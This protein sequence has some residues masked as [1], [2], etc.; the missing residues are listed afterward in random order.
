MSGL[1]VIEDQT[2]GTAW[3]QSTPTGHQR[4]SPT[5]ILGRRGATSLCPK[6]ASPQINYEALVNLVAFIDQYGR[7]MPPL[8]RVSKPQT[9]MPRIV[10]HK[11]Q[12]AL[13]D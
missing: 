7:M 3:P 1:E 6:L 10:I 4:G 13:S 12:F 8:E 2:L 9:S 5:T 11:K